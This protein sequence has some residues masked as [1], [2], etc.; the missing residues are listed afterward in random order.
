MVYPWHV[1]SAVVGL[2]SRRKETSEYVVNGLRLEG[3]WVEFT[4]L[5]EKTTVLG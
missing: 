3:V 4:S 5:R 2:F 1:S